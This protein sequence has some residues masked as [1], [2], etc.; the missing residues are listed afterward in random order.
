MNNV[1]PKFERKKNKEPIKA[2][3]SQST[4]NRR[5][6]IPI[7]AV[8]CVLLLIFSSWLY[9]LN[10]NLS[11]G[12][13]EN[14]LDISVEMNE[15]ADN[16]R[17]FIINNATELI[18][19]N[20]GFNRNITSFK[21]Q[22]N[23]N[24]A[25]EIFTNYQPY[26]KNKNR[27]EVIVKYWSLEVEPEF[28]YTQDLIR[29]PVIDLENDAKFDMSIIGIYEDN[30]YPYTY[31]INLELIISASKKT[32]DESKFTERIYSFTEPLKLPNLFIEYKFWQFQNNAQTAN[33]DIAR[34]M[35]YI[36]TTLARMRA[37]TKQRYGEGNSHKNVLSEGDIELAL[38]LALILEE[39]LLFRAY[40]PASASSIDRFFYNSGE[41]EYPTNP[42]GKRQWGSSEISNY[43]EY[44]TRRTYIN[45]PSTRLMT[46]L[47]EQYVN[48]GYL[49][50]A[51]ILGL[52][53]I[54]DK[55]SRAAIIGTPKDKEAIL[56]EKYETKYLFDP[57]TPNSR[58]DTT[59]LKFILNL[60]DDFKS[61]FNF[62]KDTVNFIDHQE[63]GLLVDQEPN[64]L[65]VDNDFIIQGL[66]SARGWYSTAILRPGT[67]T[68]TSVVIP[69]RPEEH[70]YR[71]EWKLRILGNVE[72]NIR[73]SLEL[74]NSKA[75]GLWLTKELELDLPVNIFLWFNTD[76]LITSVH[77]D[78]LNKGTATAG[79]WEITSESTLVEYFESRL[80]EYL[81]PLFA[82]GFDE[83]YSI[84][85]SILTESGYE[86]FYDGNN[87][88]SEKLL[89]SDAN[90]ISMLISNILLYQTQHVDRIFQRDIDVLWNRFNIFMSKYF[91][92]YLGQ[93][94]EYDFFNY[95]DKPQ[96]PHPPL[97][98]WLSEIGYSINLHYSKE[99][100]ICNLTMI[101]DNGYITLHIHGY[102]SDLAQFQVQVTTFMELPKLFKLKTQ[103]STEK[104]DGNRPQ[105]TGI[106]VLYNTYPFETQT[107]SKP[108]TNTGVD[109]NENLLQS[110]SRF[111]DL[112]KL[113][114]IQLENLTFTNSPNL[115]DHDK[116]IKISIY[117]PANLRSGQ[118][119]LG[120]I[121]NDLPVNGKY[122]SNQNPSISDKLIQTRVN[123]AEYLSS[124]TE[125]MLNW[126][127][128]NYS[129]TKFAIDFS[130]NST[131]AI[132]SNQCRNLTIF[133]NEPLTAK[134]FLSW[135]GV[136]G[137]NLFIKLWVINDVALDLESEFIEL[138]L[139]SG[140][141]FTREDLNGLDIEVYSN[142]VNNEKY[143]RLSVVDNLL[144]IYKYPYQDR[145]NLIMISSTIDRTLINVGRKGLSSDISSG[146]NTDSRSLEMIKQDYICYRYENNKSYKVQLLLGVNWYKIV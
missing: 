56:D 36:L 35:R 99:T 20:P 16:I 60:P 72:I 107:Y 1:P 17:D 46:S 26:N 73:P 95:T 78:D 7:T 123:V 39:A 59:N 87:R 18:I 64:Y 8:G 114:E 32:S 3:I 74:Y 12:L 57:R 48:T 142:I 106:G 9:Y 24:L 146:S 131:G 118:T 96:F 15:A 134:K 58:T 4:K 14:N 94:K 103:L 136:H 70:S 108:I 128:N 91:L 117:S 86:Y 47:I 62:T 11:I 120:K 83:V 105:Y 93:Y 124:L 75:N 19:Y 101:L 52:Y 133:L 65:I 51:D 121:I 137:V 22:L 113:T 23:V 119:Q 90:L 144:E 127:E 21:N 130:I 68:R 28:K 25:K 85:P 40:D 50:P 98:P 53:L 33:S 145:N 129:N 79:A 132:Q 138:L 77:F 30:R 122:S 10:E 31:L 6:G 126:I 43:Y 88:Y 116:Q 27:V 141:G 135:L 2:V 29:Y 104:N 97:F 5:K 100:N 67:E 140:S 71:L 69:E 110:R 61:G 115:S 55:G 34:M 143:S 80:W 76:P 82:L 112:Y 37:Y 13:P 139:N 92:D 89:F 49:D 41:S 125:A 109:S 66:D 63:L 38:N 111:V 54:L 45:D 42:T 102:D 44:L 81:S 84:I